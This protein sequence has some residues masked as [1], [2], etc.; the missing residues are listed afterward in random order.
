MA[1]GCVSS[2]CKAGRVLLCVQWFAWCMQV[3][4]LFAAAV[5]IAI[6]RPA[7]CGLHGVYHVVVWPRAISYVHVERLST[8]SRFGRESSC[9]QTGMASAFCCDTQQP[10]WWCFAVLAQP[11]AGSRLCAALVC[12]VFERHQCLTGSKAAT[13]LQE[14]CVAGALHAPPCPEG[15]VFLLLA[16][17]AAALMD[18][19]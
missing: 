6:D 17:C 16:C 1:Q 8:S 11:L 3:K 5:F 4:L 15:V 9:T 7:C 2:L 12:V 14:L 19:R 18:A 10:P 13:A